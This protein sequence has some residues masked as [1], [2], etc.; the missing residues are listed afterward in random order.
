MRAVLLEM[1]GQ[2]EVWASISETTRI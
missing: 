2:E 1:N